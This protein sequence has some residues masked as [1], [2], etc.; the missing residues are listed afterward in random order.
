MTARGKIDLA[1]PPFL[2]RSNSYSVPNGPVFQA[3]KELLMLFRKMIKKKREEI[4]EWGWAGSF[5]QSWIPK[6]AYQIHDAS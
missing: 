3:S 4:R 6:E 5:Q 1:F 2:W